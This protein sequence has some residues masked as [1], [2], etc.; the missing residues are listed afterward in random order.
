MRVDDGKVALQVAAVEGSDVVCTVTVGGTV[1]G[2]KGL[3]LSEK[4]VADLEFA[5]RLGVDLVALSFVRS[6]ATPT[7]S[8]RS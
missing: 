7:S 6:P 8:T 3:S 2:N 5:L 4:D 1:S